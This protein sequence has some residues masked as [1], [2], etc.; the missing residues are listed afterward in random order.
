MGVRLRSDNQVP[1][2][3]PGV[4]KTSHQGCPRPYTRGAQD[5]TPGVPK[6]L[7]Q[8]CLSAARRIS[9]APFWAHNL[10]VILLMMKK[11]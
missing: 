8:G 11:T 2:L 1:D 7:H 3:T 5:L 6:T 10:L 9:V 4:P